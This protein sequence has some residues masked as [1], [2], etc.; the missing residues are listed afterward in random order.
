MFVQRRS[1]LQIWFACTISL[2]FEPGL[3]PFQSEEMQQQAIEV[4]Q[5]AMQKYSVEKDIAQYIKKEVWRSMS[6]KCYRWKKHATDRV[7]V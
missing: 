5:D 2:H 7:L 4:A 3:T 1:S 6:R